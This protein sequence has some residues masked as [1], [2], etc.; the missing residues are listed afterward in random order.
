LEFHDSKI[1]Y[2]AVNTSFGFQCTVIF[3]VLAKDN[4]LYI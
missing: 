2:F 4:Y 1:I 3:L